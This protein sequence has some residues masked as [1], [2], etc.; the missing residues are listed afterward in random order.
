MI[1]KTFHQTYSKYADL[2][3]ELQE[4]I[5]RIRQKNPGWSHQFYSNEDC[6]EF[7]FEEYGADVLSSYEMINPLYRAARADLFRY[8][9]VYKTGGCYIDIKSTVTQDL[10]S[11]LSESDQF[12][13]SKWRNKPGEKFEGWGIYED[14]GIDEYQQ[15]HIIAMPGHP[16]LAAVIEEVL[17]NIRSYN[18]FSCGVGALGVL[19]MTGPIVY[20]KAIQRAFDPSLHREVD[21]ESL[22]IEYSIF[23]KQELK[24]RPGHYSSLRE[25]L[26]LNSRVHH[27]L[28]RMGLGSRIW[29]NKKK[30]Q[31]ARVQK[32]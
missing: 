2:P 12:I 3:E 9:L 19:R 10:T 6:K 31:K 16:Y 14:E 1:P 4:N 15:W 25:P 17:K 22:G 26:V 30:K 7:I 11:S 24:A 29:R 13:L 18:P 28:A 27:L 5:H 21:I 20:T 23:S 8:L 32:K